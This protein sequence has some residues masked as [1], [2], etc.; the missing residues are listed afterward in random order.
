MLKRVWLPPQ[1]GSHHVRVEFQPHPPSS[2]RR[3][4]GPIFAEGSSPLKRGK[5]TTGR[6]SAILP[7]STALEAPRLAKLMPTSENSKLPG[8][9]NHPEPCCLGPV[10]GPVSLLPKEQ[11]GPPYTPIPWWCSKMV[12]SPVI[13]I[14]SHTKGVPTPKKTAHT[15]FLPL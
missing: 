6:R 15:M 2:L 4:G 3:H 1:L 9:G 11:D 10:R 7:F 8:N 12:V 5:Q 14:Y 13:S